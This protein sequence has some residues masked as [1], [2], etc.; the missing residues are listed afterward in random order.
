MERGKG[1]MK[2]AGERAKGKL[3]EGKAKTE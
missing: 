3:K 1:K 2:A